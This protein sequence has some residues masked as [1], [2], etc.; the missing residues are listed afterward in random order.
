[1][2]R[3]VGKTV[4]ITGAASGLGR[5]AAELFAAEG[6]CVVIADVVDGDEVVDA[7]DDADGEASFVTATRSRRRSSS[8]CTPTAASTCCS[9]TPG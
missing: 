2:D 7:I 1:M 6:A 4:V 5:V 9:T 3:L 8:P